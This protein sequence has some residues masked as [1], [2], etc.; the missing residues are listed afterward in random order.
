MY[1]CIHYVSTYLDVWVE[2]RWVELKRD[3]SKPKYGDDIY[4]LMM[5][6]VRYQNGYT[7]LQRSTLGG[8]TDITKLLIDGG[9]DVNSID[10]IVSDIIW[11]I[12]VVIACLLNCVLKLYDC[13]NVVISSIKR[14]HQH[15]HWYKCD[16]D[17]SHK[18][19]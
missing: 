15:P 7:A 12:V 10:N 19:V 9:A 1:D 18:Y 2:L 8:Y 14:H 4:N 16:L 13:C 11:G 17:N 3:F 6:W 5:Y